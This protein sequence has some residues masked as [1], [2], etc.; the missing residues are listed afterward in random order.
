MTPEHEFMNTVGWVFIGLAISCAVIIMRRFWGAEDDED[1]HQIA[2]NLPLETH[3]FH[4][5]LSYSTYF[6][7]V[8]GLC[9]IWMF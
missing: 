6:F 2:M 1:I 4:Q 7:L 3:M 9:M 8:C 5:N